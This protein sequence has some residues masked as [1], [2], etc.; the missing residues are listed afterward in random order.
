MS[1]LKH[2]FSIEKDYNLRDVPKDDDEQP[3][4][5]VDECNKHK[6]VFVIYEQF[7]EIISLRVFFFVGFFYCHR[8]VL[9]EIQER[10]DWLEEME[11]LGEGHIY[12]PIIKN[13]IEERLRLIKRLQPD[14]NGKRSESNGEQ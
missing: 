6:I 3:I 12:K 1:G 2:E 11:K 9:H 14:A 8:V 5:P 13:E 7:I 10:M 4:D